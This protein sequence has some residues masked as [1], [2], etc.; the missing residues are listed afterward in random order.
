MKR[1]ILSFTYIVSSIG[2][3][4]IIVSAFLKFDQV[5]LGEL[6]G[7]V[8]TIISIVLGMI[9]IVYTYRSTETSNKTYADIV[10]QYEKFESKINEICGSNNFDR[11]NIE[12]IRE[13]NIVDFK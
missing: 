6:L 5:F 2:L 8:S 10:Q 12:M 13:A 11:N 3:I 4:L 1:K 7:N 9:S